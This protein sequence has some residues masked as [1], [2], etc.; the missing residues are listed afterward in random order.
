MNSGTSNLDQLTLWS[1]EP[2]A[3]P[4]PSLASELEWLTL[5]ETSPSH[6]W[7]SLTDFGQNGLSLRTS[8]ASCLRTEEGI[9]APS[10]G[11]WLNSGMGSPTGFSTH[12]TSEFPSVVAECSLS[13][14]V[15]TGVEQ[16]PYF[17]SRKACEGILRR[18]ERKEVQLPEMVQQMIKFRVTEADSGGMD[19]E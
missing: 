7:L 11:R 14:I 10:S 8:Q 2:L 3:N 6:T 15:Q 5:V 4:S 12:N 1:G 16:Q 13:Q 19:D 9:L 18:V 17:L